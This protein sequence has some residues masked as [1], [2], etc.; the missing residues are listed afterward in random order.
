[1]DNL[2][3]SSLLQSLKEAK[4]IS[5]GEAYPSRAIKVEATDVKNWLEKTDC[6]QSQ[7]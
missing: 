7:K 1:M 2:L 4:A 6:Q 3:F 5:N